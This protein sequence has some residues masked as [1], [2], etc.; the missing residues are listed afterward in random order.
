MHRAENRDSIQQRTERDPKKNK[1]SEEKNMDIR[2]ERFLEKRLESIDQSGEI[3]NT[4]K[5]SM[6]AIKPSISWF[7]VTDYQKERITRR[8]Q[9]EKKSLDI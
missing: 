9:S 1:F 6:R 4:R 2:E 7:E 5:I 8:K 3:C